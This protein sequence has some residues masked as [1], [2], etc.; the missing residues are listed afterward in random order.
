MSSSTTVVPAA[1]DRPT[2][3]LDAIA[4]PRHLAIV[5]GLDAG[6]AV[7]LPPHHATIVLGR[8]VPL[9]LPAEHAVPIDHATVSRRH[10][11]L[12]VTRDGLRVTDLGSRNGTH[13]G[14]QRVH[15]ST[16]LAEGAVI[17]LGAVAVE[18]RDGPA[19]LPRR[20]PSPTHGSSPPRPFN[21][22]PR[23]APPASPPPPPELPLDDPPRTTSGG[24]SIAMVLGPV[25]FGAVL[26][27]LFSPLMAVFA[28]MG[29]ALMIGSWLERRW[30]DRRQRSRSAGVVRLSV[31]A[32]ERELRARHT[33][34]QV[35]RRSAHPD[36]ATLRRWADGGGRLWERRA[37]HDDAF[38]VTL[39]LAHQPWSPWSEHQAPAPEGSR[40]LLTAVGP[41]PDA[42]VVAPLGAGRAVGVVGPPAARDAVV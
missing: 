8:D 11:S 3:R 7:G 36:P 13:V 32:F 27:V 26:A 23:S 41:L 33:A 35:R 1:A 17:R 28:L 24:L 39:G 34:E 40:H 12:D 10:A 16:S 4:P 25:A 22:P 6:R 9:A 30:H 2:H 14:G 21:R 37:A 42:P 38:E 15:P 20:L 19:P 31:D 5:G 18:V 29:P